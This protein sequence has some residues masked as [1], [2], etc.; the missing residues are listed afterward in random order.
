MAEIVVREAVEADDIAA[1]RRLMQA[2]G[3]HLAAHP[4]G[5][6]NICLEGYKQELDG[7]PGAYT[8]LLMAVVDGAAA[9][10]VALRPLRVEER[11]CEMK[12]LWVDGGFRGL[13]L[14]RRLVEEAIRR[15]E[16]AGFEAMYLDT[17]PA[18]MP[19]A[20]RLYEARGFARVER[21]NKNAVA[22]IVFFRLGLVG[23]E[24]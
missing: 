12:R 21:Y 14:G 1:V 9:G 5:A 6:A 16:R 11:A 10:C 15:A 18:A 23:R 19:E 7:L 3:E 13:G 17:V 8:V 20:N 2:Y 24:R 4:A 22:D